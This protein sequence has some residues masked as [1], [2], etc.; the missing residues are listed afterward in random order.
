MPALHKHMSLYCLDYCHHICTLT[1]GPS[2]KSLSSDK[3]APNL[4][5]KLECNLRDE[6]V[7]KQNHRNQTY[8]KHFSK[9]TNSEV[10]L[11]IVRFNFTAWTLNFTENGL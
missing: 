9:R 11:A 2:R 4:H 8:E 6:T 10:T 5:N 3:N 7:F 1:A